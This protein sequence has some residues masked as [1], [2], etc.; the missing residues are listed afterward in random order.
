MIGEPE[1]PGRRTPRPLVVN[2]HAQSAPSG[3]YIGRKSSLSARLIASGYF[4]ATA[5]GNPFK[6]RDYAEPSEC[7]EAYRRHLWAAIQ[8]RDWAVLDVLSRIARARAPEL[9]CSCAPRP[10]H[11]DVIAEDWSYILD[12][13]TEADGARLIP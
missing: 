7:L 1:L 10:C 6:P 13:L 4:D 8:L 9:V 2:R 3:F 11:G 5:L 12:A